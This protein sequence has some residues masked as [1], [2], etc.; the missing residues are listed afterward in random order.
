MCAFL[1]ITVA[2]RVQNLFAYLGTNGK[3]TGNC[4]FHREERRSKVAEIVKEF[5]GK[6]GQ[7]PWSKGVTLGSNEW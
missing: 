4:V 2:R 6:D 1:E 7:L 3:G 5:E